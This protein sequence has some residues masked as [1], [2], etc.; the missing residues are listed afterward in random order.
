[1]QIVLTQELIMDNSHSLSIK[2]LPIPTGKKFTVII[3]R[4]HA[5]K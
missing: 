2:H 4:D 1:M 5:N 3:L